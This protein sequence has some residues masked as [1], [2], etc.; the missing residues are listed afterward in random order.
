MAKKMKGAQGGIHGFGG[1]RGDSN[2]PAPTL[3]PPLLLRDGIYHEM[4]HDLGLK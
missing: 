2:P 3:N 1:C 4:M